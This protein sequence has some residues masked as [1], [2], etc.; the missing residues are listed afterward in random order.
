[1]LALPRFTVL[2]TM[3]QGTGRSRNLLLPPIMSNTPES[4]ISVV[5]PPQAGSLGQ[6]IF[7]LSAQTWHSWLEFIYASRILNDQYTHLGLR[8]NGRCD[9]GKSSI[10]TRTGRPAPLTKHLTS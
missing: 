7:P 9:C 4:D 2:A 1:M 6:P 10:I 5:A 8:E 3:P